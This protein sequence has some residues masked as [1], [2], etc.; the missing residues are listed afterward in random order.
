LNE[1]LAVVLKKYCNGEYGFDQQIS[2]QG[3]FQLNLLR[4]L[5][6]LAS[7]FAVYLDFLKNGTVDLLSQ[8]LEESV[9]FAFE[10]A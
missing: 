5:I 3:T 1:K 2:R 10:D 4:L 7:D 6:T 9:I 8:V